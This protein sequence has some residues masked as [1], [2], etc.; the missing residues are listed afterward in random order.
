MNWRSFLP[1]LG[2]FHHGGH[3]DDRSSDSS[4]AFVTSV[5]ESSESQRFEAPRGSGFTKIAAWTLWPMLW[6]GARRPGQGSRPA[7]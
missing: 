1:S 7:T 5:V 4:V 3:G 6:K 2:V